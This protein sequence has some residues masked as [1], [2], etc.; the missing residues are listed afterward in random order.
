MTSKKNVLDHLNSSSEHTASKVTGMPVDDLRHVHQKSFP[1]VPTIRTMS[2]EPGR[3]QLSTAIFFGRAL[4]RGLTVISGDS[5]ATEVKGLDPVDALGSNLWKASF[6]NGGR[7]V[8]ELE[9]CVFHAVLEHGRL[10][11]TA[12]G[13]TTQSVAETLARVEERP[14][15]RIVSDELWNR[16]QQTRSEI[17]KALAPKQNLARGK[18]ARFHSKH[19]FTGFAKCH[20]SALT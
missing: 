12:A 8:V 3:G 10:E 9:D 17:R 4:D 13:Y 2:L 11:V 19:L 6:A 16:V 5:W 7:L 1:N 15:L 14:E 20:M 18:D